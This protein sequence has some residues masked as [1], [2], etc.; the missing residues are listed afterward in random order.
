MKRAD[1]SDTST[2]ILSSTQPILINHMNTISDPAKLTHIFEEELTE[3]VQPYAYI[4]EVFETE[5]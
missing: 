1:D 4:S 5:E 2:H 3:I